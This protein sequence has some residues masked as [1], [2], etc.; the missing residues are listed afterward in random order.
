M[1]AVEPVRRLPS[2]PGLSHVVPSAG[3]L[4]AEHQLSCLV[5]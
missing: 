1:P 4:I 2:H 5:I 3:E